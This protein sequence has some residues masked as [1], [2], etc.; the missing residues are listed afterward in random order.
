M[1]KILLLSGLMGIA[2]L[3]SSHRVSADDLQLGGTFNYITGLDENGLTNPFGSPQSG[4]NV[5]EGGGSVDP[6]F[7]NGNAL[8]FVYCV[9]IPV[10]VMVP[11]DYPATLV[12]QTGV[13]DNT[14]SIPNA[15]TIAWLV[16]QFAS[17]AIS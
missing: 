14:V 13:V 3:I 11:G 16:D 8:P 12:T 15:G 1:K 7:L 9:Q 4:M 10:S 5:T 6:S 2:V 17:T